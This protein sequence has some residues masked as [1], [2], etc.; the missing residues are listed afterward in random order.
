MFDLTDKTAL[1]TG[2]SRGI[3]R[4]IAVQLASRGARVIAAARTESALEEVVG[5]I[6]ASGGQAAA[7]RLRS[8]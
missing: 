4:S 2:A 6:A 7:L 1:V 8:A 3:G 5:E